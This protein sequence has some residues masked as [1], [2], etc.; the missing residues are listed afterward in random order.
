MK[1]LD[2]IFK[3]EDLN[4]SKLIVGILSGR[5]K[6]LMTIQGRKVDSVYFMPNLKS[7]FVESSMYPFVGGDGVKRKSSINATNIPSVNLMLPYVAP[8]FLV[9]APKEAIYDFSMVCL[10]NARNILTVLE[11]EYQLCFERNLTLNRL[12]E[13]IISPRYPDVGD[14]MSYDLNLPPSVYISNDIEKLIRLRK[15]IL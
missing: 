13:A 14:H 4:I 2:P 5:G 7:W 9:D 3:Q 12:G 8:N 11:E 1:E 6:D 10:E 15:I